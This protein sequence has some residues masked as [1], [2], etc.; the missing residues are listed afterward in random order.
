MCAFILRLFLLYLACIGLSG[1]SE[2]LI[3]AQTQYITRQGLAS[4]RIQ[5]PDPN[6]NHP[7]LGQ[8]LIIK[9]CLPDSFMSYQDLSLMV[10][11]RLHNQTQNTLVIPVCKNKDTYIFTLPGDVFCE[12]EGLVSYKIDLIGHGCVLSEWR[13]QL[14]AEPINVQ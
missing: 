12:T 7:V 2:P 13:H 9:W 14:W 5:T 8:R 6:L 3:S 4:Y 11:M 10:F 1:C